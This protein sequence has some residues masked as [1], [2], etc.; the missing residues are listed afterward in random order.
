MQ[1]Q[2][3]LGK[4]SLEQDA[5]RVRAILFSGLLIQSTDNAYYLLDTARVQQHIEFTPASWQPRSGSPTAGQIGDYAGLE[6]SIGDSEAVVFKVPKNADLHE[7]LEVRLY[8]AIAE[9]YAALSGEIQWACAFSAVPADETEQLSAAGYTG[10]LDPG[11]QDIPATASFLTYTDF[12]EINDGQELE[13][14]DIIG[15]EFKRV[16][17]DDGADPQAEPLG[18]LLTVEYTMNKFGIPLP[19]VLPARL[20]EDGEYLLLEDGT[21]RYLE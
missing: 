12:G 20:L 15:L 18:I 13:E 7:P 10:D 19:A 17:L 9:A 6:F 1:R 21:Y 11:D 4:Q 16:A 3:Q 2:R 8:W 14:E 5:R